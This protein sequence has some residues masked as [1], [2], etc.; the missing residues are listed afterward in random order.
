MKETVS[1]ERR[2]LRYLESGRI[3]PAIL[4][5]GA[6]PKKIE[7]AKLMA[8]FLLCTEKKKPCGNC[9]AC[10]R[11]EREIHPDLLIVREE[12]EDQIK[13]ETIRELAHQ[14][15]IQ[16]LEGGCKICIIDECHRMNA[17]ANNAFLKTLEEPGENRF[18]LLLTTQPGNL[19]PTLL[20]RMIQ[21]NFK[22]EAK[23]EPITAEETTA[24]QTVYS[25]FAKAQDPSLASNELGDKEQSL[26]LVKFLQV[27]LR[28]AAVGE[29]SFFSGHAA[30]TRKFEAV[31]ETEKKLHSNASHSLL[32]ESL[33]RDH[34]SDRQA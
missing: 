8:K 6:D 21:F 28:N 30:L 11:A 33:L 17:A 4:L 9:N 18:F 16:P 2:L 22:P 29:A 7:T 15:A 5:A 3:H 31:V 13:I 20:S 27:Q 24:F 32:I 10:S 1:T 19:L 34:F 12:G 23:A 14:M 25:N 26:K